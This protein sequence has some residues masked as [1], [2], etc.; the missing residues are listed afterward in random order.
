[1][2]PFFALLNISS[3]VD[4]IEILFFTCIIFKFSRWLQKDQKTNLLGYFYLGTIIFLLAYLFE[5]TTIVQFYQISWPAMLIIFMLIHQKSLQK[6]YV[7]ARTIAPS[8]YPQQA[9][10]LSLIMS[11]AFKGLQ[12]K[13]II[14]FVIEGNNALEEFIEETIAVNSPIQQSLL[15]MIIESPTTEADSIITLTHYGKI[16][17]LNGHWKKAIDPLWFDKKYEIYQTWEQEALYW[18]HHLDAL[19]FQVNPLTK[20]ITLVAQGTRAP[21]LNADKAMNIIEQY[22]K[23]NQF[24]KKEY[25][26]QQHHQAGATK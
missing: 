26:D 19:I 5:L 16:I 25:V 18:T 13:K 10:W 8:K 7:A 14:T 23:K 15:T 20:T 24:P 1:M 22:I 6:N 2:H 11:A 12:H 17:G 9:T 3:W 21:N 4:G